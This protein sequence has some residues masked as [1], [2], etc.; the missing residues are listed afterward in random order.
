[1]E[2]KQT[3]YRQRAEGISR[4]EQIDPAVIMPFLERIDREYL[5]YEKQIR[6]LRKRDF[7]RRAEEIAAYRIVYRALKKEQLHL[8]DVAYVYQ[9][10]SPLK[11]LVEAY[12]Q[13]QEKAGPCAI[14]RALHAIRTN[15]F[16]V[17]GHRLAA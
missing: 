8:E 17:S 16:D 15:Q 6:R 14:A 11:M 7:L 3:L 1:M 13:V 9:F 5:A 2:N 12:A 4:A 10:E